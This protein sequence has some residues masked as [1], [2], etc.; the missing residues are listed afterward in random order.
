MGIGDGR[1]ECTRGKWE[2][3]KEGDRRAKEEEKKL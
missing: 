3:V 2:R 1:K